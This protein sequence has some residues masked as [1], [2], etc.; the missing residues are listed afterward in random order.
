MEIEPGTYQYNFQAALPALLPTSFEAKHGSIRYLITV[1]IDRPWKF[2]L[3]YKVAFTVLKQ[4]DLNYENPA[5]KIP[6]KMEIIKTFYCGFCKTAPLCLAASIPMSGFVPGQNVSVSVDI[7]NESRIDIDDIKI[8]LKKIIFYN[9]QTPSRKTK[10]EILTEAEIRYGGIQK[11]GRGSFEQNLV[12]PAV[13]PSNLNYCRVLNVSYEVHVTAKIS[14]IH[15]NPV[16]KLPITI[17]TVPLN[18]TI[19]QNLQFAIQYPSAPSHT[20][21]P[22]G[23]N[24][25]ADAISQPNGAAMT[26]SLC[27]FYYFFCHFPN[28]TN[29]FLKRS[30]KLSGGHGKRDSTQRR[31]RAFHW[32]PTLS[33]NVPCL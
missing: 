21:S 29:S 30:A 2:D 16:I 10:E 17:G 14:G 11:R 27:E 26:N 12:I 13:P 19:P 33:S 3:T 9:S 4:L 5:L 25:F 23:Q 22:T 18:V 20:P 15:K 24:L 32:Q 6:T 8:S 1:V 7:N 28:I 31:G